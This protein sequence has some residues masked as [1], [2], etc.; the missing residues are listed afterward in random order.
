MIDW[1]WVV[2]LFHTSSILN[3]WRVFLLFFWPC[4]NVSHSVRICVFVL[5]SIC[6]G[7]SH[8]VISCRLRSNT[9]DM[10]DSGSSIRYRNEK[11]LHMELM[12]WR[13]HIFTNS[14]SRVK[15]I[16]KPNTLNPKLN[17]WIL[18]NHFLSFSDVI[19]F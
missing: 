12:P 8:I 19:K 4:R 7:S 5:N 10:Y 18:N 15:A 6:C 17:C 2:P 16:P 9:G 1:Q 3:K 13:L 11:L 14:V